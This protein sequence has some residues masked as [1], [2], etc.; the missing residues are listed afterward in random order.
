MYDES[1][2]LWYELQGDYYNPCLT[3]PTEK[4]HK[5]IGLWGQ[6]HKRYLQEHNK[7][8]YTT[9]LTSGK[10]NEYLVDVDKQTEERFERLV[11]Q[12]KQS[13]GITEQLK[14]E[15]A[16]EWVQRMNNIQAC[17]REIV[18]KEIIFG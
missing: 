17:A 11:E 12:M 14:S 9:L 15:N 4:E 2:G 8:F 1:N 3:L 18:N 5:P 7:I 10:L 16:L 6:R 13:Q